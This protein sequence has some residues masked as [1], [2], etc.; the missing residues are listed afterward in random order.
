[1]QCKLIANDRRERAK[2][3][4]LMLQVNYFKLTSVACQTFSVSYYTHICLVIIK[5]IDRRTV[6]TNNIIFYEFFKLEN[7]ICLI[8]MCMYMPDE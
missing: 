6:Y 2:C 1:M 5:I 7:L 8:S 4:S 3:G